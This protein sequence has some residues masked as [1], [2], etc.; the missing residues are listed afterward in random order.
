MA[1]CSGENTPARLARQIMHRYYSMQLSASQ[2]F[3]DQQ[4]AKGGVPSPTTRTATP[5]TSGG[6]YQSP[7][8][9]MQ[10]MIIDEYVTEKLAFKQR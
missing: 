10:Q 6:I 7:L 8:T 3:L 2:F 5:S 4:N 1:I 9:A